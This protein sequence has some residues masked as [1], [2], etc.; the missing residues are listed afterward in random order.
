MNEKEEATNSVLGRVD[1]SFQPFGA[2]DCAHHTF[3]GLRAE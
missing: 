2:D 3:I 1:I